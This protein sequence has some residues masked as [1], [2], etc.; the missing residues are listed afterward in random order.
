MFLEQIFTQSVR[1]FFLGGHFWLEEDA[2]W[3]AAR[4]FRDFFD[5]TMS[6]TAPA[7]VSFLDVVSFPETID[8]QNK[9]LSKLNKHFYA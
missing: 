6:S 9:T 5:F 3:F 8:D 4:F 2:I 7:P 1:V